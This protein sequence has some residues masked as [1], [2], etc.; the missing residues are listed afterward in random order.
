MRKHPVGLGLP[1]REPL[2]TF[3]SS[4]RAKGMRE[5]E[6]GS[7]SS[8]SGQSLQSAEVEVQHQAV[9]MGQ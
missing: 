4:P 1:N 7:G 8:E 5:Q 2:Q 9:Q 3:F 6:I